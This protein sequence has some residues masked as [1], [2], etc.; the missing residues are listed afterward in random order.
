M[1]LEL[2]AHMR[3]R[4]DQERQREEAKVDNLLRGGGT[5]TDVAA[6]DSAKAVL[7]EGG[8]IEDMLKAAIQGHRE[9]V[10]EDVM[11]ETETETNLSQI[12]NLFPRPPGTEE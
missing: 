11:P 7:E 2:Y 3:Q 9:A 10:G 4:Q 8:S 6:F 1:A 12:L 5:L